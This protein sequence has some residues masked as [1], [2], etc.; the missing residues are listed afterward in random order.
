[1]MEMLDSFVNNS[2]YLLTIHIEHEIAFS[3]NEY[4]ETSVGTQT[5]LSICI[6][7]LIQKQ[8]HNYGIILT[9]RTTF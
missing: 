9:T 5:N 1:M 2:I 3:T 6:F 8:M 4:P 7:I